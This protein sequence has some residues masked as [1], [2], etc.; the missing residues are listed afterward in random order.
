M[1]QIVLILAVAACVLAGC[2]NSPKTGIDV[3]GRWYESLD[4]QGA[5]IDSTSFFIFSDDQQFARR[6][7]N[8][9]SLEV[10]DYACSSDTKEDYGDHP[11]K[12]V[13]LSTGTGEVYYV[14]IVS[15]LTSKELKKFK[16]TNPD[17][18]VVW[19]WVFTY[20][21]NNKEQIKYFVKDETYVAPQQ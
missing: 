12:R 4:E 5:E 16:K 7:H 20:R 19:M 17:K 11:S 21:I 10:G 13:S 3:L 8:A 18:Q 9:G 15:P 14:D 6:Y 2:S 1:K